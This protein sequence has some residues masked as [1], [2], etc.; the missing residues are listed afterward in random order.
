MAETHDEALA[1]ASSLGTPFG[2]LE[3]QLLAVLAALAPC[4]SIR[5]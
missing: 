2:G 4:S 3:G 1:W 5:S